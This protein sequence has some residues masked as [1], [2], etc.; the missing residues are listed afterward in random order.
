M[1]SMLTV[2]HYVHVFMGFAVII[3]RLHYKSITKIRLAKMLCEKK[4]MN[5]V[6]SYTHLPEWRRS[7]MGV[8]PSPWQP[9]PNSDASIAATQFVAIATKEKMFNPKIQPTKFTPPVQRKNF[10]EALQRH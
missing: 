1:M 4:K 8:A 5:I 10:K 7:E 9:P 3:S 2:G 6:C